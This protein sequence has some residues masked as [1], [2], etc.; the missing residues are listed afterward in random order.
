MLLTLPGLSFGQANNAEGLTEI[1]PELVESRIEQAEAS[2]VYDEPT[3]ASAVD[4]YRRVLANLNAANAYLEAATQFEQARADAPAETQRLQSSLER[5]RSRD[6]LAAL[7]GIEGSAARD[8]EQRL[9]QERANEAELK[10]KRAEFGQKLAAEEFRPQA[11]RQRVTAANQELR[12]ITDQLSSPP[13]SRS[14]RSQPRA[15]CHH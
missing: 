12:I 4:F 9:Q 10:A 13:W 14:S 6:P 15:M 3:R 1:T 7:K 2:S 11:A 8:I 5:K